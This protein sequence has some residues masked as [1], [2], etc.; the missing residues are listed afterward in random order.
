MTQRPLNRLNDILPMLARGRF[1]ERCDEHLARAFEEMSTHPDGAA[2]ASVTIT[3][4]LAYDGERVEV[5]PRVQ[6]K[7]PDE[8]GFKASTFFA[9]KGGVSTQHP[10]QMDMFPR[11]VGA[12][13]RKASEQ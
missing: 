4:A 12:D 11:A 3:L 8:K 1:V 9:V 13:D 10:N 2:K 6:S 7:L 5:T